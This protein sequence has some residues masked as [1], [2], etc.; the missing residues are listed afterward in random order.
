[1]PTFA[2][3]IHTYIYIY[4]FATVID[5]LYKVLKVSLGIGPRGTMCT[6]SL[7]RFLEPYPKTCIEMTTE[8]IPREILHLSSGG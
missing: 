6:M 3:Y 8:S 7:T 2:Y 5:F 1:M 4:I